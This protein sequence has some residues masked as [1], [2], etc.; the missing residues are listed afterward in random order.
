MLQLAT[1]AHLNRIRT[2]WIETRTWAET[3]GQLTR[4]AL[5]FGAIFIAIGLGEFLFVTIN[6]PRLPYGSGVGGLPNLADKNFAYRFWIFLVIRSRGLGLYR[7]RG[8]VALSIFT[9]LSLWGRILGP[10]PTIWFV[11]NV[12]DIIMGITLVAVGRRMNGRKAKIAAL[13]LCVGMLV[14]KYFAMLN[15]IRVWEKGTTYDAVRHSQRAIAWC[16]S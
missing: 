15:A 2:K 10:P 1:E 5:F 4:G 13:F 6:K 8:A 14:L 11:K 9:A 16:C 3:E 12:Y 7:D